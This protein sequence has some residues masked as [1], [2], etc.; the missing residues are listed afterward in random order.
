M[1]ACIDGLGVPGIVM[2]VS[3]CDVVGGGRNGE[4]I[5]DQENMPREMQNPSVV[6]AP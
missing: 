3:L 1:R 4:H 6:P 5:L 2:Y